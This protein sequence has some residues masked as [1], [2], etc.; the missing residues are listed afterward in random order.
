M[1][2]LANCNPVEFLVQTGKIRH[3]VEN[4]L[5]LTKIMEI[6]KNT[7]VIPE[8]ASV[9]DIRAIREKAVK[10][11]LSNI[12]TSILDEHPQET[13]VLLGLCCFVEPEDIEKHK[14]TEFLGAAAEIIG[15]KDVLDFFI[16]LQKLGEN[17]IL[18]LSKQ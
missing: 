8:G 9:A 17:N 16:S 11:N 4:W 13:A 3:A 15:D 10:E 12:L 18:T 5:S 14:M 7:P 6:R 1:K 2:N